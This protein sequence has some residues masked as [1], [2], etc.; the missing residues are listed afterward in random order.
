MVKPQRCVWN[1][2]F[3]TVQKYSIETCSQLATPPHRRPLW[4]TKVFERNSINAA[5]NNVFAAGCADHHLLK[6]PTACEGDLDRDGQVAPSD[7]LSIPS[8]WGC[9]DRNRSVDGNN[10]TGLEDG[11]AVLAVWEPCTA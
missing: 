1:L 8:E 4:S 7:V 11:I 6:V 5:N 9:P 2:L 3:I 10:A